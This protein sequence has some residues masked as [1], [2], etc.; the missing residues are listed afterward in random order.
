MYGS[1]RCF[2]SRTFSERAMSR[3]LNVLVLGGWSPGPLDAL[4]WAVRNEPVDFHE[5]AMHMPPAGTRWCCTWQAALLG[6]CVM[7]AVNAMS[8]LGSSSPLQPLAAQL[9][10]LVGSAGA[11]VFAIMLLVR[12]SIQRCVATAERTI[13][14]H[15]VDVV[16]GFSWGGGIACWLLAKQQ[17][18]GPTLL[19]A[20]TVAGM[21]SAAR[22]PKPVFSAASSAEATARMAAESPPAL[23]HIFHASDDTFFCPD[24]QHAALAASGAAMHICEDDIH[25]FANRQSERRIVDTFASMLAAVRTPPSGS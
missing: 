20:P 10:L 11:V 12:G 22:L 14:Q 23:V 16:V 13:A 24:S 15:G 18:R 5:P 9:A 17:W 7:I 19:L 1:Q 6:A 8:L 25:I 4:R 3:R 21:A 2:H